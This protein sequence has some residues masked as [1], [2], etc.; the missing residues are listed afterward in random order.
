MINS[1]VK[2]KLRLKKAMRGIVKSLSGQS[3][4]PDVNVVEEAVAAGSN[5]QLAL[6]VG[7]HLGVPGTDESESIF[8]NGPVDSGFVGEFIGGVLLGLEGLAVARL[9]KSVGG[10][11]VEDN[12]DR[13]GDKIGDVGFDFGNAVF[14]AFE[15]LSNDKCGSILEVGLPVPPPLAFPC[16]GEMLLVGGGGE[17]GVAPDVVLTFE[18]TSTLFLPPPPGPTQLKLIPL[19]PRESFS[20]TFGDTDPD[21]SQLL[22]S[23]TGDGPWNPYPEFLPPVL[24]LGPNPIPIV[25]IIPDRITLAV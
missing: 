16:I 19:I 25:P 23:R 13:L 21:P 11:M 2:F 14:T 18:G 15:K 12:G 10:D 6:R 1:I 5:A 8:Q 3:T 17:A 20:R 9:G 7:I 22:S 24:P 4:V